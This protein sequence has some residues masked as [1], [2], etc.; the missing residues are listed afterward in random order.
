MKTLLVTGCAGFIGS[1]FCER[2]QD[3][4]EI[5]GV[6][7]LT[8]GSHPANIAPCIKFHRLDILSE[9]GLR[10]VFRAHPGIEAIVNFAGETH[11]DDSLKD[12]TP[13]WATNVLGLKNL[14]KI[15]LERKIRL[16]HMS[17]DEVYGPSADNRIFAETD[18]LNPS[19]PYAASK[20]AGDM[21]L[22]SYHHSY[23]LDCVI[24]R[25]CNILGPRQS[26]EKLVPKAIFHLQRDKPFPLYRT[27]AKRVWLSIDDL[28]LA[29]ATL[30]REGR[31]GQIYNVGPDHDHE[32]ETAALVGQ[33]RSLIGK[34]NVTTVCDR[35]AYDLRYLIS[36]GKIRKELNWTATKNLKQV[37]EETVAWYQ[38]N[39][40]W[41]ETYPFKDAS[42]E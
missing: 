16:L 25:G 17:T 15:A 28:C 4:F 8:R 32:I 29:L 2:F 34:G 1:N 10:G 39:P 31:S 36:A 26:L 27:P 21:L 20:A 24:A 35:R 19:N 5:V 33:I 22:L 30:L 41:V 7:A 12:D 6:D 9:D 42:P 13:F 11:V 23:G 40:R 37:I 14:A 38:N 3:E 18:P